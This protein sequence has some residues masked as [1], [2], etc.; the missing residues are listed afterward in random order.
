MFYQIKEDAHKAAYRRLEHLLSDE[1]ILLCFGDRLTLASMSMVPVVAEALCAACSKENEA[2]DILK[3][4]KPS[5]LFTSELLEQGNGIDLIRQSQA[6]ASPPKCLV[7]LRRETR[8]LVEDALDAGASGVVFVSRL[9]D[10]GSGD[11]MQALQ[12]VLAGGIYVPLTVRS[13]LTEEMQEQPGW[14]SE[15]TIREL[16]VLQL[17]AEGASNA[18]MAGSLNLSVP[19]IKTHLAS[20]YSKMGVS[21]RVKCLVAAVRAKIV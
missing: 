8:E 20:V 9:G 11:F 18:E 13:V 4:E 6:S 10:D 16:E 14:V 12:T 2:L 5:L 21:D 19:T 15:I 3:I 7:F 1:R 17:L